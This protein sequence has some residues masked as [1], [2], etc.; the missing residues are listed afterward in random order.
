MID[1]RA[2]AVAGTGAIDW[3]LLEGWRAWVCASVKGGASTG[4]ED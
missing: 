4:A 2:E 3:N 1:V